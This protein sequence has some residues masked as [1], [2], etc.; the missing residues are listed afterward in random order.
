V[1]PIYL[2][3]NAT[4]PTDPGVFRAML[5]YLSGGAGAGARD[6][7]FGNPSSTHAYGTAARDAVAGAR[8]RVAALLGA[9]PDEIVFTGG[10][11]ESSNH[12]VKR[13]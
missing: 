2:D 11:S 7:H 1:T 8:A 6:H 4:T 10:G 12:A 5:P 3:Y 13:P 9:H